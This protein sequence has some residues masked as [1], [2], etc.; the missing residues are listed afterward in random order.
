MRWGEKYWINHRDTETRRH[1]E[2]TKSII[3]TD[4]NRWTQIR[5][6]RIFYFGNLSSLCLCVSVPL[7]FIL[8]GFHN[9]M[10]GRPLWV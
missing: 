5:E 8:L 10:V 1:R 6:D 9:N 2:K 3:A 4:E 7:W